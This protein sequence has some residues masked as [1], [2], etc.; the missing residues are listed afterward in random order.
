MKLTL[1]SITKLK[2]INPRL[3]YSKNR[4]NNNNNDGAIF[5]W[6]MEKQI[7][8]NHKY[9]LDQRLTSSLAKENSW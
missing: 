4:N 5:D 7:Q 2:K 3:R 8:S 9:R 1:L 6:V